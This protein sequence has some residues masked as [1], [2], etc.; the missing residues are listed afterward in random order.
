MNNTFLFLSISGSYTSP[1]FVSGAYLVRRSRF[2]KFGLP[3]FFQNQLIHSHKTVFKH[4]S[5]NIVH[6]NSQ[7]I[8]IRIEKNSSPV[9][10][11][12]SSIIGIT[13][14]GNGGAMLLS[15]VD[16]TIVRCYFINCS[17][18]RGGAFHQTQ[19][20]THVTRTCFYSCSGVSTSDQTGRC[21]YSYSCSR[22]INYTTFSY[23]AKSVSEGGDSTFFCSYGL[24]IVK[25]INI[26]K[27]YG[28]NGSAGGEFWYPDA[29]NV[30]SLS[31]VV[32][33][34]DYN[35]L[36]CV[37]KSM[38]FQFINLIDMP[39]LTTCLLYG[40][41]QGTLTLTDS[42][43]INCIHHLAYSQIFLRV[44]SD[45]AYGSGVTVVMNPSSLCLDVY[46]C[47]NIAITPSMYYNGKIRNS[48]HA[49]LLSQ[50]LVYY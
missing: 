23:C 9:T 18:L 22:L 31:T 6:I 43:I 36:G 1:Y 46:A 12:D 27:C 20:K 7:I 14:S 25:G 47:E 8:S 44:L 16:L 48:I 4:F 40:Q 37:Y 42:V 29:N 30:Y 3:L 39:Y 35:S 2:S 24:S 17:S 38:T 19:G 15:N 11:V 34:I 45:Y 32:D 13:N 50:A 49:V 10:L 26:S 21:F 28:R 33:C 41:D 5:S